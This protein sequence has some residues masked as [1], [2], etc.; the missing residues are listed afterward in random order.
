MSFL[1]PEAIILSSGLKAKE[2][3][4]SVWPSR[5]FQ[6]WTPEEASQSLKVLSLLPEAN[7]SGGAEGDGGHIAVVA[8]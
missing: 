5:G 4:S 2:I 3:T 7:H 1:L 6:A 8:L